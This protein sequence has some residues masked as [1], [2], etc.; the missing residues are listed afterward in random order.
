MIES[1]PAAVDPTSNCA[2]P[3]NFSALSTRFTSTRRNAWGRV[4]KTTA[5]LP[6]KLT[7]LFISW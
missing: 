1:S 3:A 2:S 6:V 7:C 5:L 4:S